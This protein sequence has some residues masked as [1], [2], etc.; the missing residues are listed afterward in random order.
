MNY[1]VTTEKYST[2]TCRTSVLARIDCHTEDQARKARGALALRY[3]D[4]DD[5]GHSVTATVIRTA[6]GVKVR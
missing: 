5:S 3:L 2:V 1:T 6:A 4:A